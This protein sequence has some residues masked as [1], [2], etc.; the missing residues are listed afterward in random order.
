MNSFIYETFKYLKTKQPELAF[1]VIISQ[2][3]FKR[4]LKKYGELVK[5]YTYFTVSVAMKTTSQKTLFLFSL[6]CIC[7]SFAFYTDVFLS[8]A[9]EE[10]FF[11]K[12]NDPSLIM[13]LLGDLRR[14]SK[15]VLFWSGF[16]LLTVLKIIF[17]IF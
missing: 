7:I 17:I 16:C 5:C 14:A 10:L 11:L 3:S 1:S 9:N 8:S 4:S 15:I 2:I 12:G 6:F 13:Q